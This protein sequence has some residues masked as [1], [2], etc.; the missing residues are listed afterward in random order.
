MVEF[1]RD[2][3]FWIRSSLIKRKHDLFKNGIKNE[4]QFEEY[5][6]LLDLIEKLSK[7]L[8]EQDKLKMEQAT[9][10]A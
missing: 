7:Y 6:R 3:M 10:G 5:G 2:E 8:V 4:L 9:K 1:T